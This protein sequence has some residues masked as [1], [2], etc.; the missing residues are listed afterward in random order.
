LARTTGCFQGVR[1]IKEFPAFTA[2]K[3]RELETLYVTIFTGS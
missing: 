2:A 1:K 3:R